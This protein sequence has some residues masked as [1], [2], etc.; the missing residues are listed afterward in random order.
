ML[1]DQPLKVPAAPAGTVP[2]VPFCRS[3]TCTA[4]TPWPRCSPPWPGC[5]FL[6]IPNIPTQ[7][8]HWAHPGSWPIPPTKGCYCKGRGHRELEPRTG[9]C[10]WGNPMLSWPLQRGH[11]VLPSVPEVPNQR[12][13]NC[14][15]HGSH[16]Q[17]RCL[18]R[19]QMGPQAWPRMEMRKKGWSWV[20]VLEIFRKM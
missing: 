9:L 20:L 14:D 5:C 19:L 6:K 15:S 7:A 16:Q 1:K 10:P 11:K 17:G 12:H 3:R 18:G 2:R 13:S 4:S 8:T